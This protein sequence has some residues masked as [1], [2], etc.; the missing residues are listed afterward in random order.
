MV[1][2]I[3]PKSLPCPVVCGV[4]IES[5]VKFMPV[6]FR[7]PPKSVW[8]A[9]VLGGRAIRIPRAVWEG[10]GTLFNLRR[11]TRFTSKKREK[12][13]FFASELM[14]RCGISVGTAIERAP[15]LPTARTAKK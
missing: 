12:P 1:P 10:R 3:F 13:Y 9:S 15:F 4:V 8:R 6:E 14:G 7:G 2:V 5:T 11:G